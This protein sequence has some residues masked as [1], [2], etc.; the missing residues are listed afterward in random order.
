MAATADTNRRDGPGESAP[1]LW[2]RWLVTVIVAIAAYGAI[3]VVRGTVPAALFDALGF[4]MT[5]SGITAP[6]A[7]SYVLFIYG[8]LGAVLIGWMLLLLAVARGPLLR[9]ER[10]AWNAVAQ[11]MTVWFLVDTAF[12][13]SVGSPAHALFNV[14]FAVVIA[15]PL[16]ALR[17]YRGAS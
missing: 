1:S 16:V 10:W 13:L 17:R 4:G 5:G 3:L 7:T 8:V 9:R 12:S 2:D 15:A 11:S 6:P 14:G